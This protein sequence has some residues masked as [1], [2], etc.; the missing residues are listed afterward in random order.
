[1]SQNDLDKDNGELTRRV[2][3]FYSNKTIQRNYNYM[4]Y[5][6]KS[7]KL[8]NL[9]RCTTEDLEKTLDLYATN[10]ELPSGYEYKKE[11]YEIGPF[12][13]SFPVLD[14]N[15]FEFTIKLEEDSEATV[16]NLILVLNRAII[17]SNGYYN[18]FSNVV[19]DDLE[20]SVYKHDGTNLYRVFFQNCYLLKASTPS[21][22]YNTNEKIEYELT[23]NA[24]HF[25]VTY[26]KA[27]SNSD[28]QAL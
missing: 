1:M 15:G 27:A 5:F 25:Y 26:G 2:R 22:S 24:D 10:V 16:K 8:Q 17:D 9:L 20:I 6:S 13:K 28:F 14:H 18:N 7:T 3:H 23:F 21:F 12:K 11:Y 4:V 19:L